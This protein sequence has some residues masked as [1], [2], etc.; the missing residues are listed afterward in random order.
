[1]YQW[2]YTFN[3]S[4]FSP[5]EK[6]TNPFGRP[7]ILT[8][9]NLRQLVKIALS[10]PHDFGLPFAAWSVAKLS[11]YCRSRGLLPDVSNEWIRRL[12]RREGLSLKGSPDPA[13][14]K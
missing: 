5:F 9:E 12:L 6:A 1:M 2:V 3:E 11:E 13:F 8:P 4:G 14:E 7:A 10:R